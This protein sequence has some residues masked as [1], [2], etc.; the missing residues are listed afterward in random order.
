[1]PSSPCF[2]APL[3]S[4]RGQRRTTPG[5]APAPRGAAGRPA[6]AR[7]GACRGQ[8]GPS[9]PTAPA[10]AQLQARTTPTPTG[11]ASGP[12]QSPSPRMCCGGPSWWRASGCATSAAAWAWRA[13][14]RR[15]QVGGAAALGR[16]RCP[17]HTAVPGALQPGGFGGSAGALRGLEP[18][19]GPG[20]L[21]KPGPCAAAPC[22]RPN[23]GRAIHARLGPWPAVLTCCA[24]RARAPPLR[25]RVGGGAHGPRAHGAAVRGA[26][27]S[28]Q[29]AAQ[30]AAPGPPASQQPAA[31]LRRG[32]QQQPLG[33][34]QQQ[35]RRRRGAAAASRQRGCSRPQRQVG[36][37]RGRRC[38]SC[39]FAA[40]R[41]AR[42]PRACC[43]SQA[44]LPCLSPCCM[45]PAALRPAALRQP[46]HPDAPPG[47]ELGGWSW[48]PGRPLIRKGPLIPCRVTVQM[49]DWNSPD[50]SQK[51]DTVL[52]CDVLY[53]PAAVDPIAAMV[54]PGAACLCA[55]HAQA[56][57][58]AVAAHGGRRWGVAAVPRAHRQLI[59]RSDLRPCLPWLRPQVPKILKTSGGQLLLADPPNRTKHNRERCAP[60]AR[61]ARHRPQRPRACPPCY[62]YQP[63]NPPARPPPPAA[64]AGS[65]RS[66]GRRR[67][68]W[69]WRRAAS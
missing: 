40:A 63:A 19:R 51:F 64:R 61:P 14:P 35:R 27:R 10:A 8:A 56:C 48:R 12:R 53:E 1:V 34:H 44:A 6:A 28:G 54:R 60:P 65:W 25:R 21:P 17:W 67:R 43:A 18:S 31:L 3:G 39:R 29:R 69:F 24:A 37:R 11:R 66:C 2:L 45:R 33:R 13:S 58:S 4:T 46:G 41:V 23:P 52:A 26:E 16:W 36:A 49:F 62:A 50:L 38:S 20:R 9:P 59:A 68:A 42:P 5:R 57:C 7:R 15:S 47:A 32:P 55:A 30:R 22:T